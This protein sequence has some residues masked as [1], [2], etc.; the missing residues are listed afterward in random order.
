MAMQLD[1]FLPHQASHARVWS[2]L[3]A[4]VRQAV[5]EHL[6]H[7]M[8]RTVLQPVCGQETDDG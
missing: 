2:T 6:A 3:D 4:A 7:L 8:A 1:L 5:L